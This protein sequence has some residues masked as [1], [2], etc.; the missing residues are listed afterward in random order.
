MKRIILGFA[1]LTL[2]SPARAAS[3]GH[4]IDQLTWM[5]GTWQATEGSGADS[6]IVT[7]KAWLSPNG[8]AIFYH[9]NVTYAGKTT[10]R[11]DGMY[12]WHPASK[13]FAIRQVSADG[14]VSEGELELVG[15]HAEQRTTT[16]GLDSSQA[17]IKADYTIASD[18]F[19]LVA[20][21][22]AADAKEWIPALDTVY[23]K[24]P[25]EK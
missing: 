7:L 15:N 19:H 18:H 13:A 8:N 3:E 1:L 20:Q 22:K 17:Q 16:I 4:P 21:F 12:Y 25:S 23:R 24:T 11:Y 14:R 10:P 6:Q 5:V 9:V 2:I